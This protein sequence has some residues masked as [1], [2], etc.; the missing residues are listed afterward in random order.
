MSLS[1]SLVTT[2]LSLNL[3]FA[4]AVGMAA[5]VRLTPAQKK[6]SGPAMIR[7]MLDFIVFQSTLVETPA[8]FAKYM[9]RGMNETDRKAVTQALA[10]Q[11]E[12]PS[13]QRIGDVLVVDNKMYKVEV[14]FLEIGKYDLEVN[15]I[16]WTYNPAEPFMPQFDKLQEKLKQKK[17]AAWFQLVPEAEAVVWLAPLVPFA[18]MAAGAII[19]TLTSDVTKEGWCKWDPLVSASC[20][21]LRKQAEDALFKD[22]PALDAV[23]NQA[24][25]DN[26]NILADYESDDWNCPTNNDG[27][28][29]EYRGRIRKVETKD[30]KTTP[31]SNWFNVVAK[32]TPQGL[33]T[34]LIITTDNAD[35]ATVDTSP[36][37]SS[38]SLI[39]HIAFDPSKKK[40]ISYRM[41]NPTYNGGRDLL[42]SPV[43]TL[44][45]TQKLTPEQSSH[46]ANAK[47]IVQLIN[48][49]NYNCVAK[50]IEK[51]QL[52]GIS[53]T[54]PAD[55]IKSTPASAEIIK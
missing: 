20:A 35:P 48:F 41:P 55:A 15:G 25:S 8:D 2:L 44:T 30:G 26:R 5:E 28:D 11:K 1:K 34:D 4:P 52:A 45:P 33:P 3:I 27:K 51:D 42:G 39:I 38:G 17:N 40:P 49:R 46:V 50:K 19:G 21:E 54:T 14:R 13:F 23:S 53:P 22:A 29:R 9:L 24:G 7:T 16:K 43:V 18:L 6:A 47:G 37:K 10:S 32:F 31:I 12:F 36:K